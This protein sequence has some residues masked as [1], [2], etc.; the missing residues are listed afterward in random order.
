MEL[1]CFFLP[2]SNRA[3]KIISEDKKYMY[4]A[5]T[6]D[7]NSFMISTFQKRI[8]YCGILYNDTEAVLHKIQVKKEF[9]EFITIGGYID[10]FASSYFKYNNKE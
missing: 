4:N 8:F 2:E 3:V 5:N 1:V 6:S 7:D 10:M 9:I